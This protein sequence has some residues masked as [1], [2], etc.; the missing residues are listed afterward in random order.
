MESRSAWVWDE[1]GTWGPQSSPAGNHR[2]LWVI[3]Q[4]RVS[5]IG[6]VAFQVVVSPGSGCER[7]KKGSLM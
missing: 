4:S 6:S 1:S 3:P 7:N 2:V 5:F